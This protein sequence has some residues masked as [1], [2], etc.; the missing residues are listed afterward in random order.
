[1]VP[2]ERLI[3]AASGMAGVRACVCVDST[4]V[5]ANKGGGVERKKVNFVEPSVE[6]KVNNS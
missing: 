1:M 4:K 5:Q 2:S 6:K 3:C